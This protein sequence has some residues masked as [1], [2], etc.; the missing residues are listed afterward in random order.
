MPSTTLARGNAISTF[1]IG[2]SITPAAV[3]A[4]TT[5]AQTFNLPGLQTTDIIVSQGY[6]ANQTV[7]I[8]IA[9]CD[10]LTAGV[11]TIQFGNVTAGSV[12]PAAGIYEFNIARPENLPLPTTAV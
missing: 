7:G 1:Y 2:P 3:A 4:N 5:A 9:E 12:T 6:I 10:C 8:F 11:L